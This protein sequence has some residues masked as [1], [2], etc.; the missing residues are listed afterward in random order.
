MV[1]AERPIYLDHA[2]TTPTDPRVV[3]AMLPYF[4]DVYGNP[5]ST[6]GFGRQ[7][8]KAV[9][10]ARDTIAQILG[11]ER[12]EIIFTSCGTESNNIALRSMVYRAETLGKLAH[13]LTAR[14]EHHAISHTAAQLALL[15]GVLVSW[16]SVRRDGTVTPEALKEA[17][18]PDGNTTLV[19]V[20]YANN[21]VG[22]IQPIGELAEIAH[23]RGALFHSDAVQAAGQLPLKV[24]ELGVDMLSLTAHK[25]YGPKGVGLLYVR[26]DLDVIPAQT[27]GGQESNRRAG[28]HNVPFIVGMA[29]AL[30]LAYAELTERVAHFHH[31]RDTLISGVLAAVPGTQLTGGDVDHRLPNHASFIIDGIDAN[32]LLMH[33]DLSGIAASSGSACNTGSPE[34]SDVLLAMGYDEKAAMSSL[35]LTVGRQTTMTDVDTLLAVLPEAVHRVRQVRE[36]HRTTA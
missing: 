20:M 16:L 6:H 22:T 12:G 5:S 19:S 3:E 13:L 31:L 32:Q 1:R 28:T 30:E 14:T 29:K 34:P 23:S 33:L 17:L 27:G 8:A 25:F 24:G 11:S 9:E 10:Q 7:A 26:R 36:A 4:S 15:Q 2:A 18:F 35:R 21:E